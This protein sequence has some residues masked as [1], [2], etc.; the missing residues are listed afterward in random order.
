MALCLL[1]LLYSIYLATFS[2]AYHSSDEMS[3][4][5]ATDSLARRG[6]WD[7]EL[8][9]WMGEQQGSFGPDGHLYSRKGIGMTLAALP[10]YWLAL[11]FDRLGNVQTGM[12]TNAIVTAL[13]GAL[14]FLSLR[15]LHFGQG[16]SLL[17]ALAFGI[18]TMAW[19]YARYFFS[20]SLAALGLMLSFYFLL[21]FRDSAVPVSAILAG[22]GLGIAMLARLNN[23]LA[24]PFLGLLLLAYLYRRHGRDW[25]SYVAP[26]V[27]FALPVLG[28]LAITGW[29]NWH[30]FGS[31]LTTG[32]LPEENFAT[33]FLEGLYGLTL[34]AGKGL[35]W[36]NPLLIAAVAAWPAFY[37]RH[38]AEALLIAAV[39][40][41]T[42]FFY[43]PWYLWWAGHGWGPRFLVSLLPFAAL[44]LAAAFA[45][46]ARHR[47]LAVALAAIAAASLAVQVL[48]VAVDFNLYLEDAYAE[49][50]LYHPAT[51]FDLA[52]SPLIRQWAYLGHGNL[53]LAWARGGAIDGLALVGSLA[54]VL[55]SA[56][57]LLAVM[58]AR[59]RRIW[60]ALALVALPL[61]ATLP[62]LARYAPEGDVAWVSR[63]L[64]AAERSGEAAAVTASPLTE[65]F[66]DT[67][68]GRLPLWGV[69][70]IEAIGGEPTAAWRVGHSTVEDAIDPAAA[71]A[72]AR[73][74]SGDS[75][76]AFFPAP[77]KALEPPRL[78]APQPEPRPELGGAV[79]LAGVEVARDRIGPGETLD[80]SLYWR[81]LTPMRTSYTIFVQLVDANGTKA[82]QVDRLPCGGAC[83]TT[84]WHPGDVVGERYELAVR[85]DAAPGSYRLIA[86]MYDLATG[87]RLP[88][89]HTPAT[90]SDRDHI[91]LGTT[92]VTP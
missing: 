60:P 87:E 24:A 73:F 86:G 55:A 11:Q 17:A 13:T 37:R 19:P 51:L 69:P 76:A 25:R 49:L 2:G 38:R 91:L 63:A 35:F 39:V 75:Y 21:H 7:I 10:H 65:P 81:G 85:D 92:E 18:G 34:S 82:G 72:A 33:P 52:Y 53:D 42:I 3:M 22:A 61:L 29:Y 66:Q 43:A 9:R 83:P 8:L 78:P 62:V 41:S 36:Y 56:G 89:R 12:L 47:G 79:A 64:A 15:R 30:R 67:Y 57:A 28:A 46:A 26:V 31:A 68:D 14:V 84:A 71:P 77:G 70:S 4:L 6:A 80:V 5:V 40:L 44:P 20:E 45:L 48:G 1:A 58:R 50:G 23:A 16:V 27:L 88:V 59:R 90:A 54:L 32:Y 74:Q